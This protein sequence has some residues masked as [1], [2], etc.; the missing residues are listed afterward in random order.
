[1]PDSVDREQLA[2]Q[3]TE[4]LGARPPDALLDVWTGAAPV[5]N[6]SFSVFGPDEI[7]GL[8]ADYQIAAFRPDLLLVGSDGDLGMFVARGEVDPH[9]L[10]I[11]V[12]AVGSDDGIDAGPLSALAASGFRTLPLDPG[13]PAEDPTAPVDVLVTGRPDAGAKGL[14]E[15]RRVL[16]SD[17]PIGDL[18]GPG[19]GYPVTVLRAVPYQRYRARIDDLQSR[20]GCLAVRPSA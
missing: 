6:D 5:D 8:N 11:D 15:I 18:A 4:R 9:A 2:R 12:G 3:V 16:G 7:A 17:V 13:P 20:Y 14:Y 10:L 19:A 1:V